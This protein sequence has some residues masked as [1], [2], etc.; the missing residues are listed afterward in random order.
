MTTATLLAVDDEVLLLQLFTRRLERLSYKVYSAKSGEKALEI[1][2]HE[3][4]DI[5]VTDFRMPGMNGGELI[6]QAVQI[7][8]IL[9]TIVVTGYSDSTTA[10]EIMAAGAFQYLP[11]PID[12]NELDIS[13]RQG[14]K[15]RRLLQDLQEALNK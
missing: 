6:A 3:D 13:I 14:L 11:K 4:I 2:R 7:D 15:K 5:L 8:P 9:Q 1:L 10:E 12:F